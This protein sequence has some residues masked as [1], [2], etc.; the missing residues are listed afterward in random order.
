MATTPEQMTLVTTE[1]AERNEQAYK[2]RLE[3]PLKQVFHNLCA[4]LETQCATVTTELNNPQAIALAKARIKTLRHQSTFLALSFM[5]NQIYC[6][7]SVPMAEPD[8]NAHFKDIL[9]RTA[10]YCLKLGVSADYWDKT[11]KDLMS[12]LLRLNVQIGPTVSFLKRDALWRPYAERLFNRVSDHITLAE[13]RLATAE[14]TL[15]AQ[16]LKQSLSLS[17][18]KHLQAL[19]T[20]E[21]AKN[22]LKS[23]HFQFQWFLEDNVQNTLTLFCDRYKIANE[24]KESFIKLGFYASDWARLFDSL[25]DA[26]LQN[27]L[28]TLKARCES[29]ISSHQRLLSAELRDEGETGQFATFAKRLTNFFELLHTR[30]R[31]THENLAKRKETYLSLGF[32]AD[33]WQQIPGFLVAAIRQILFCDNNP[34]QR[35]AAILSEIKNIFAENITAQTLLDASQESTVIHVPTALF[36]LHRLLEPVAT[37][38]QFQCIRTVSDFRSHRNKTQAEAALLALEQMLTHIEHTLCLA[39]PMETEEIT[40]ALRAHHE[41]LAGTRKQLTATALEPTEPVIIPAPSIENTKT[42]VIPATTRIIDT[43]KKEPQPTTRLLVNAALDRLDTSGCFAFET[44]V[45]EG[46]EF[47]Q[48]ENLVFFITDKHDAAT[49]LHYN[50]IVSAYFLQALKG[51]QVDK[52]IFWARCLLSSKQNYGMECEPMGKNGRDPLWILCKHPSR[53]PDL[54]VHYEKMAIEIL[55]DATWKQRLTHS[56]TLGD[57]FLSDMPQQD[58]LKGFKVNA[59]TL[60]SFM[61]IALLYGHGTAALHFAREHTTLFSKAYINAAKVNPQRETAIFYRLFEVKKP[62]L[63]EAS[64]TVLRQI[65]EIQAIF[66]NQL[67]KPCPVELIPPTFHFMKHL[68]YLFTPHVFAVEAFGIQQRV[69]RATFCYLLQSKMTEKH[70]KKG[71]ELALKICTAVINATSIQQIYEALTPSFLDAPQFEIQATSLRR[72]LIEAF[73]GE[74]EGASSVLGVTREQIPHYT[75]DKPSQKAMGALLTLALQPTVGETFSAHCLQTVD[76]TLKAYLL[77]CGQMNPART[78]GIEN[79]LDCWRQLHALERKDSE[80]KM[81]STLIRFIQG[82][83]KF[84]PGSFRFELVSELYQQPEVKATLRL[85]GAADRAKLVEALKQY[86]SQLATPSQAPSATLFDPA[87]AGGTASPSSGANRANAS[88]NTSFSN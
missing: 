83:V 80:S 42:M 21:K 35:A 15:L 43:E 1:E 19:G 26:V 75:W 27:Q 4:A 17:A 23:K 29:E 10:N 84:K 36:P 67:A 48:V 82:G 78:K 81:L 31:D 37:E 70:G 86:R 5:M 79:A 44:A 68:L 47:S 57:N 34:K 39:L 28:D 60:F 16:A 33:E 62:L 22:E 18:T 7:P 51:D 46:C 2:Q 30:M 87:N 63:S 77:A 73:L 25:L 54:L 55:G 59:L 11:L 3:E 12:E 41:T 32:N 64:Y 50:K 13:Q 61:D 52:I 69:Q 76:K 8:G 85:E 49:Q 6:L 74:P 66:D 65:F 45:N 56:L 38:V 58:R 24:L 20:D 72:L 9:Q 71:T 88:D 40:L 14:T 53:A